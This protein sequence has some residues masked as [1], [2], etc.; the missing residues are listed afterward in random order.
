M[1]NNN[2]LGVEHF[3]KTIKPGFMDHK[4]QKFD[5]VIIVNVT[6]CKPTLV[7]ITATTGAGG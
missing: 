4:R 2:L 3:I 6:P 5:K 7:V 1:G